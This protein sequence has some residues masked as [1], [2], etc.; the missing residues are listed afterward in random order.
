MVDAQ[1][2]SAVRETLDEV[3]DPCSAFT[4]Q[5]VS[6]VDL[7]LVDA[8]SVDDGDVTVELLPTNQLCMYMMNIQDE[9]EE[10]VTDLSRVDSVTVEQ[11]TDK[12]WT[13]DR[14]SDEEYRRRHE[15]FQQR[16]DE[17][18]V[19]PYYDQEGQPTT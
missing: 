16:V 4:D 19:T 6:I 2:E 17:H 12:V 3:I 15:R 9:V 11:V 14:M 10:R 5:P 1:L 13:Q 8:V 7:G 18:D